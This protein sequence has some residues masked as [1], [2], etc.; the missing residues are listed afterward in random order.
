MQTR[1]VGD[2]WRMSNRDV[3]VALRDPSRAGS[4]AKHLSERRV[5]PTLVF[6]CRDLLEQVRRKHYSLVVLDPQLSCPHG[7][8]CVDETRRI[9]PAPIVALQTAGSDESQAV[10]LELDLNEEGR[11]VARH[12]AAL[13]ELT[14]PVDLP[15]PIQWGP[16]DLDMRTHQASWR[17]NALPLTTLQFRI[18]EVLALAAGALVTNEQLSRRVWGEDSF[19]D[20]DRLVAH[21]R[22]IR[23]LI[24]TDSS[25]PE[26]LLRVRGRGFRLADVRKE[27]Q[28]P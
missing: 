16:L 28:E 25:M 7:L 12:G 24:E 1:R 13:V 10:D 17:G 18:M 9:S 6:S 21:V 23:K 5:I 20:D 26:F 27:P 3:L 4:V 22:R 14:R 8:R 19:G 2:R 15:H 11:E